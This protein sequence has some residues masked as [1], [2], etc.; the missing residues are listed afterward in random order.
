MV[1]QNERFI[2]TNNV[3]FDPGNSC[4]ETVSTRTCQVF[5][6][7]NVE[8]IP[9][10]HFTKVAMHQLLTFEPVNDK[11][12]SM[13]CGPSGD[14]DKLVQIVTM[15]YQLLIECKEKSKKLSGHD[16]LS[17]CWAH[18]SLCWF[19]HALTHFSEVD[20]TNI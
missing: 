7:N 10:K 18:I 5:W 1:K 20:S 6:V 13:T 17:I 3:V 11:T 15:R 12:N 19:N 8:S 16:D 2:A 4:S 14:T 9:L